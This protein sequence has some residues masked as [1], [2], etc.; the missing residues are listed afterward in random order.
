MNLEP[1][2]K[3]PRDAVTPRVRARQALKERLGRHLQEPKSHVENSVRAEGTRRTPFRTADVLLMCDSAHEDLALVA[4]R[5][6]AGAR[7]LRAREAVAGPTRHVPAS[8][9][10]AVR[11]CS[12]S[13]AVSSLPC[14]GS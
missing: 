4:G 5:H 12:R 11:E 6:A 8:G 9:I 2:E 1:A 13:H 10:L 3:G 7:C 14:A